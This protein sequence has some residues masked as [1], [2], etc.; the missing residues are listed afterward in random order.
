MTAKTAAI[1]TVQYERARRDGHVLG[2]AYV[3]LLRGAKL[4][5]NNAKIREKF[6]CKNICKSMTYDSY[7]FHLS[8]YRFYQP[9]GGSVVT[10][11]MLHT[12]DFLQGAITGA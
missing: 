9:Q 4:S 10:E 2:S 12:F 3:I 7:V 5:I 6:S 11:N 8:T 1:I